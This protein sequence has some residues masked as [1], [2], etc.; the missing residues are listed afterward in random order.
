MRTQEFTVNGIEYTAVCI[1]EKQAFK[2]AL[3]EG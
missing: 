3:N 2:Q 1:Q